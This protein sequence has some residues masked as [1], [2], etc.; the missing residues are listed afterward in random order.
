MLF[1]FTIIAGLLALYLM[2][3]PYNL[4]RNYITARKTGLPIIVVPID[5]NHFIWMVTS[6]ALRPII[7]VRLL[8]PLPCSQ[9]IAHFQES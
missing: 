9:A 2:T 7:K 3:F 4:A 6:V 8:G 1:L 5:Q